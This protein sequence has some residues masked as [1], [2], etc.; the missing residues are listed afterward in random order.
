[1]YFD[2]YP[3]SNLKDFFNYKEEYAKVKEALKKGVPIT[4]IIGVRR[5][6]KT[7]LMNVLFNE[8]NERKVWI[9]GRIIKDPKTEIPLAITKSLESRKPM[10]FGKIESISVSVMGLSINLK[11]NEE[12]NRNIEDMIGNKKLFVFIDEAQRMKTMEL[13]ELLSYFYDRHSGIKFILSGSEVGLMEEVLGGDASTHPLYGRLIVKI[14]MSRL[15]KEK[16]FEFLKAGFKQVNVKVSKKELNQAV[17]RLDGLIGWLTMYGYERGVLNKKNALKITEERA[18]GIVMSELSAFLR[19]RRNREMYLNIIKYAKGGIEWKAL[20]TA[21]EAERK[22][23]INPNVL[24]FAIDELLRYSFLE[25]QG[26]KYILPDPLLFT[27]VM[28]GL[29]K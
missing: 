23:P 17:D 18:V 14:K 9:D 29:V 5:T 24:A 28:K 11:T 25:K 1:M 27:A 19:N 3:K 8:L 2:I 12:F 16:S 22:K 15:T 7:S 26:N 21:L 10:V 4:A 13:A 6:G 20:K